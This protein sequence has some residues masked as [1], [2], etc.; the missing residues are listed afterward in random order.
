M[1]LSVAQSCLT[2]WDPMGCS[3]PGF[4]VL[5]VSQSLFKFMFTESLYES[6]NPQ[7]LHVAVSHLN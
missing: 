6:I 7:T 1:L 5:T 2:L 3:T 4:S